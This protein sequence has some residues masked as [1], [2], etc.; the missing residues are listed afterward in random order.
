MEA[1][2]LSIKIHFLIGEA[3]TLSDLKSQPQS[4]SPLNNND[5]ENAFELCRENDWQ[6]NMQPA[7]SRIFIILNRYANQLTKWLRR[8]GGRSS[9]GPTAMDLLWFFLTSSMTLRSIMLLCLSGGSPWG[10]LT[11]Q[12]KCWR[13]HI[14]NS[15]RKGMT[16]LRNLYHWIPHVMWCNA[17]EAVH[18]IHFN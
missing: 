14:Y 6:S 11:W 1:R 18:T 8:C 10:Y 17:L 13:F 2:N 16:E 12:I 3:S 9:N 4:D 15:A 5:T 7:N